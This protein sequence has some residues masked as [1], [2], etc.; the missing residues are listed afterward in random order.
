MTYV[1]NNAT[2]FPPESIHDHTKRIPVV[3]PR[4]LVF[5]FGAEHGDGLASPD[6]AE[7][8]QCILRAVLRQRV[9]IL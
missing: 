5:K 1:L 9:V 8:V 6:G 4:H 7:N 3:Q 2:I